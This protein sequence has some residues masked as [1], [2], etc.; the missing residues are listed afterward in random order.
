VQD[1]VEP[2]H[3]EEHAEPGSFGH[4]AKYVAPYVRIRARR[5]DSPDA[6]AQQRSARLILN[7]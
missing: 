2:C 3:A 1:L 4:R 7:F 5:L 6:Q